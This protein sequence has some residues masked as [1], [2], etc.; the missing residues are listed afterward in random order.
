[1][2][3]RE[4][5]DP[6]HPAVS[7]H[8]EPGGAVDERGTREGGQ[9]REGEA[10]L[11][12]GEGATHLPRASPPRA[13]VDAEY[14]V[15]VEHRNQ[16]VEVSAPRGGEE[17]VDELSLADRIEVRY[18]GT[19]HP[20]ACATGELPCRGGRALHQRSDLVER[21]RE[22]VV[23]HEREPLGRCQRLEHD[24]QREPDRVREQRLMLRVDALL[25]TDDRLGNAGLQGL[26]AP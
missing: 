16:R 2:P 21:D 1:M 3:D 4:A 26:L 24:E 22:H 10:P 7:R 14:D 18:R 13:A 23:Q 5:G 12:N 9:T 20:A 17:G 15:G 8:D 25:G 6:E 11:G 19:L